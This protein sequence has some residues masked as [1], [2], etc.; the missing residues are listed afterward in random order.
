VEATV[1][2]PATGHAAQ[3]ELDQYGTWAMYCRCDGA[4]RTNPWGDSMTEKDAREAVLDHK[5]ETA[6]ER[7]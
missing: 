3:Y 1:P 4:D 2:D 5:L 7:M 6:T